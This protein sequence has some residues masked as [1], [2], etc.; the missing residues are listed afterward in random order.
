MRR[1]KF[2][3]ELF[4]IELQ[5]GTISSVKVLSDYDECFDY[6]LRDTRPITRKNRPLSPRRRDMIDKYYRQGIE[7]RDIAREYGVGSSTIRVTIK[8]TML[9][10]RNTYRGLF[11]HGLEYFISKDVESVSAMTYKG[12]R[13]G[14][15]ELGF[16]SRLTNVLKRAGYFYLDDLNGVEFSR[17]KTTKGI[18][19]V[20]LSL[21]ER[22]L[23]DGYIIY[24]D[25]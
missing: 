23:P 10:Y 4:D 6:M 18:G 16:D 8:N 24:Y 14:I 9:L 15:A 2:L 11:L 1:E 20:Y 12:V 17:L 13:I 7:L 21:L 19:R 5:K 22:K 3:S 25:R